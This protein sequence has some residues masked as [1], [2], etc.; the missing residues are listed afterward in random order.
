MPMNRRE[1]VAVGAGALAMSTWPA[2]LRRRP[3]GK[4]RLILLGTGGGPRP[5]VNRIAS[6]QVILVNDIAYVVDC[7]E[8]VVRQLVAVGVPLTRVRHILI[9]HQHSDHR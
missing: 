9:T 5:R 8:G 7:G 6:S 1:F 3:P 4:T 2:L